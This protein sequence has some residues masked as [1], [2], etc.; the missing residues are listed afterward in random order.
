MI[1]FQ[2]GP[3]RFPD[4]L[5]Q[6][7]YVEFIQNTL[8]VILQQIPRIDNHEVWYMQDGA[9]AHTGRNTIQALNELFPNKYDIFLFVNIFNLILYSNFIEFLKFN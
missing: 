2:V 5:R 4:R 6:E 1:T 7:D 8:P 3:V 9:P